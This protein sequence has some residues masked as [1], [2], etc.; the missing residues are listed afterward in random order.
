MQVSADFNENQA[1]A[2][3]VENDILLLEISVVLVA[4][5]FILVLLFGQPLFEQ[6]QIYSVLIQRK[7]PH[8]ELILSNLLLNSSRAQTWA[9]RLVPAL[10]QLRRQAAR[11]SRPYRRYSGVVS[12]LQLVQRRAL[13]RL[14][15]R[16]RRRAVYGGQLDQFGR[17][18]RL[19]VRLRSTSSC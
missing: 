17:R 6:Q 3:V 5:L 4:E 19:V 1:L 12:Q 16:D 2:E 11:Q 8:L 9:L 14:G 7:V 13:L 18:S 10:V 15:D